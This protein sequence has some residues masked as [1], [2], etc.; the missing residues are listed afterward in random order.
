[1]P[2]WFRGLAASGVSPRSLGLH[3]ILS[4]SASLSLWGSDLP[5]QLLSTR[6]S[7]VSDEVAKNF[8]S[9]GAGVLAGSETLMPL[10][11]EPRLWSP[12]DPAAL[13]PWDPLP[14]KFPRP[15]LLLHRRDQEWGQQRRSPPRL[16]I[17]L[18]PTNSSSFRCLLSGVWF[19]CLSVASSGTA[20]AP[21][22]GVERGTQKRAKGP[23]DQG[24]RDCR[25]RDAA[26]ICFDSQRY[27]RS[28]SRRRRR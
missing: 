3:R 4:L 5:L 19:D 20:A 21:A 26:S 15:P 28:R 9:G 23:L 18:A 7:D 14:S 25:C 6:L 17:C 2:G 13:T 8:L 10:R 1:M 22:P 24:R 27:R 11:L 12:R 16:S